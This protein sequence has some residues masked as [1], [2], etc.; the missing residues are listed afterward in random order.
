MVPAQRGKLVIHSSQVARLG[1]SGD[2]RREGED[3]QPNNAR[4]CDIVVEGGD[5]S[6]FVFIRVMHV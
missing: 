4:N 3:E 2:S 1:N 5:G 6:I